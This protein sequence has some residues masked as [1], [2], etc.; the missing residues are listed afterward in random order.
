MSCLGMATAHSNFTL[1]H[2][3]YQLV[4]NP[5]PPLCPLSLLPL[6]PLF[7]FVAPRPHAHTHSPIPQKRHSPG[8]M[9]P[10]FEAATYALQVGQ[11]SE[12]VFTDSG[13]HL[14][15]RTA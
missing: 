5:H 11:L 14:I 6:F 13:V 3:A 15:L 8:Q 1:C 12:P 7:P 2:P 10:P 4:T 9:Q